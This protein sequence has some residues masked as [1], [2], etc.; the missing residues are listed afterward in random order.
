MPQYQ[1][2]KKANAD[3]LQEIEAMRREIEEAR[4]LKRYSA[5]NSLEGSPLHT[6]KE[7]RYSKPYQVKLRPT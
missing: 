3:M 2:L 7:P 6:L 5:M 1:E 4:E